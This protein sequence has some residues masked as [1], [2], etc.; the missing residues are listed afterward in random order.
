MIRS[1][2]RKPTSK[3]TTATLWPSKAKAAPRAAVDVVLPTPPLPD[4]TT[5]I[6]DMF[7]RPLSVE[8]SDSDVIQFEPSLNGLPAH[9]GSDLVRGQIDPR[10]RQE[11][12]LQATAKN[13]RLRLALGSC[14]GAPAERAVNVNGTA[15]D[16]ICSRSDR[17][18]YGHVALKVLN[19]LTRPH[20]RIDHERRNGVRPQ[21]GF[22]WLGRRRPAIDR[23]RVC[24]FQKRSEEHTSELQS[25][26]DLVCRL[27]LEK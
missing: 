25:H 10:N 22:A 24:N 20:G 27:L 16:D 15:G 6:L 12:R 13:A 5:I 9:I 21:R 4:V 7:P 1:R 26:H 3:S 23:E 19:S 11:L 14:K 2:L 8:P 18:N 17:A